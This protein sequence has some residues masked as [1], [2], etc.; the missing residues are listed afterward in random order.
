MLGEI[1]NVFKQNVLI[2]QIGD[3][4]PVINL[5]GHS[6]TGYFA[7]IPMT[8]IQIQIAGHF[9]HAAS[10]RIRGNLPVHVEGDYS[11]FTLPRLT[12]YELIVLN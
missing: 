4:H 10:V 12:D 1:L 5:S 7:P 8:D 9:K 6:Q 2:E 11:S 3:C